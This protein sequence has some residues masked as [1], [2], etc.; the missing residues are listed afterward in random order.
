MILPILLDKTKLLPI[1]VVGIGFKQDQYNIV[2]KD[3]FHSY[4][5]LYCTA[6]SGIF[7]ADGKE[8]K[9]GV[10]DAFFF[11]PNIPH[12]YRP[13][14]RPWKTKWITYSGN[15]AEGIADYLGLDDT[16]VFSL[17]N[18]TE[19]DL[20][21]KSLSDV[22]K[23]NKADKEIKS[24]CILYKMLIKIGGYRNNLPQ[25]GGMTQNEKFQ[26]LNPV[27]ELMKNKYNEDLSLE[28]MAAEIGVTANHLCRLFNQV[29]GVTPL[30]YL[31]QLRLNEAK[32]FL[33]SN[34]EIKIKDIAEAIG[35][36]DASYFCSVFKKSEGMTAEEFRR[37]NTF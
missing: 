29:Y 14:K 16:A 19:F 32:N 34:S 18:L 11:R 24:S 30:K 7:I 25:N 8:Y 23:S 21:T 5:I 36:N 6:G 28:A 10:G 37:I 35:F 13:A 2:R 27:I 31:T 1:Y 3:G 33:S 12:E 15:S 26:K 22:F 17:P 4:Q 9:I 20:L